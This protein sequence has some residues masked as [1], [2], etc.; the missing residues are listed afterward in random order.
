MNTFQGSRLKRRLVEVGITAITAAVVLVGARSAQAQETLIGLNTNNQ[1]FSFSSATPSVFTS[2][3]TVTGIS[4]S[5]V[6]IDFR[7][8][9][10]FL[11]GLTQSSTL[12]LYTIN[13]ITGVA[14][15]V[16]T[17]R[18][19]DNSTTLSAT[20]NTY[21]IDFNPVANAL[22][23]VGDNGDNYRLG[24]ANF[25]TGVTFIDTSLSGATSIVGAAYTNNVFNATQTTLYDLSSSSDQLYLQGSLNGT[26]NSPNGGLLT[27]VGNANVNITNET[28]FDISG[29][30]GTAYAV[31]NVPG[32]A[33]TLYTVN[34]NT[35]AFVP[36]AGAAFDARFGTVRG[37][38]APAG[39]A[40][41]PGSLALVSM[42][43]LGM[44]GGFAKR[45]RK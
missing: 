28:G 27:S 18:T 26:P 45:R 8:A 25:A 3:I 10:G 11:Y 19:P 7:P 15:L 4:G 23:I 21:D 35:G 9:N 44:V 17:L 33:S 40:P 32:N 34:L 13:T 41:E 39:V 30:T 36:P 2:L 20:A 16:S 5:L 14:S 6:D 1:I 24:A 38:A 43:L 31:T 42:G 12:N 29:V 37:I 22:R